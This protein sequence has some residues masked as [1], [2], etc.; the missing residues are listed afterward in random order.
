MT[1]KTHK[2][3]NELNEPGVGERNQTKCINRAG[4]GGGGGIEGNNSP[5]K[6]AFKEKR[7]GRRGE[8][9]GLS[10]GAREEG[11]GLISS[12]SFLF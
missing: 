6:T 4:W 11:G 12:L 3:A 7:A 10:V 5:R 1:G 9:A 8:G 2:V